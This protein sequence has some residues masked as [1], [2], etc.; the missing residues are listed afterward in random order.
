MTKRAPYRYPPHVRLLVLERLAAG[1]RLKD[2]CRGD[3]MPCAESVTGWM[4]A[5]P[6][7]AAAVAQARLRGDD[8]RRRFDPARAEAFLARA[9]AGASIPWP[10]SWARVRT[11]RRRSVQLRNT[12]GWTEGTV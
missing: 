6:G 2:I 4:R 9:R 11:S 1:E 8:A 5:G 10:S 12:Y 7:F 3:G